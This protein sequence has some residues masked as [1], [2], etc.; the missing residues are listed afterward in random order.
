MAE[1]FFGLGYVG[2]TNMCCRAHEGHDVVGFDINELKVNTIN[3]GFSP[4]TEPNIAEMLAFGVKNKRIKTFTEINDRLNDCN[5]AIVCVG[6]P[7][8]P[9]GSHNMSYI[10][11]VTYQIATHVNKNRNKK[12]T[13]VYRSTIRPGTM[14]GLITNIFR[15]VIGKNYH[16]IIELIYN[17][18]FIRESCA[19]QDYFSPPKIVIG[20]I[21]GAESLQMNLFYKNIKAPRFITHFAE[22]EI[23]KFIDNTWHAVKVSFA[24]EIGRICHQLNIS[25]KKAYEIFV[26]DTKLNISSYYLRPGGAFGGSCLPKDV[27]AL[28]YISSDC[29]ANTPLID[30]IIRSNDAH[31][32]RIFQICTQNLKNNARVLLAGLA[33]KA[34]TDDLRESPN[35]DLA[36]MLIRNGYEISIFDPTIDSNKLIGANLGYAWSHLPELNNLLISQEEAESRHFDRVIAA[37][38]TIHLLS[39][40]V[41]QDILDINT[42]G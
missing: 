41:N 16:E 31:K 27:R 5:M 2:I 33:F 35:V 21:D 19:V 4:I 40:P 34:N 28:Q 6:T 13:V 22:A 10:T 18:E 3:N 17:P 39:L 36:R 20:T 12:L 7:S 15:S 29:G 23:T 38:S 32:Y 30:S 25:A 11:N 8:L 14:N 9:D 1:A 42:L 37:N 24:N 26:A